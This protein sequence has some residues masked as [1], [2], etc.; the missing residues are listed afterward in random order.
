[1][2]LLAQNA[3]PALSARQ[4]PGLKVLFLTEM[5]ERF[6][7]YGMR[8]LLV[9]YLV[10]SLGY[11]SA[12]ALSLYGTYTMLVYITPLVGGWIADR[13]LGMRL[14]AFVGG[15]VM[16]LGHF[17]MAVPALLQIALGLLV[18]GNGLLK[19]NT[20][21]MV[22]ELYDGPAD[23]RRDGGY[24]IFYMG[25][26]LGA[27]FSG[28]VCGAVGETFGWHFGFAT[29]GA[30]MA[31]G[32]CTFVGG[33]RLLARAGLRAGQRALGRHDL[34]V[35]AAFVSGSV[36]LDLAV[37]AGWPWLGGLLAALSWAR[38]LACA[39]ALALPLLL[40]WRRA[41][42]R[43]HVPLTPAERRRVQAICVLAAFLVF[44]W[45]GVEQA[46]GSMSLFA[47]RQTD[48]RVAG[49]EFPASWFQSVDALFIVALAPF[50]S[51]LWTR[52]NNSR[53]PL[54]DVAKLG[55]S[56]MVMGLGFVVMHIA[57][58]HA[59][60]QGGSVGPQWLFGAYF[61]LAA[62]EV[63]LSPVGL[64]LLSRAAPA[65]SA[66]LLMGVWMLA[67]ALANKLAGSLEGL[68]AGSGIAPYFLLMNISIGLGLLLLALSPLL[69][70]MLRRA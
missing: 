4:P 70:R 18:I 55:L 65:R 33:Q 15:V 21:S 40:L 52:I 12:D 69:T 43:S 57:Q 47:D 59:G 14:A 34:P 60:R 31:V 6:S 10:H 27:I 1:M 9:L 63:M 25:I 45:T 58:H 3:D 56:M 13:F 22:G 61:F 36:A 53:W 35:V 42:A 23:P 32:L 16:M 39:A 48:R 19:P 49:F 5:W 11:T 68:L 50:L 7:F 64:S 28:L 46:G 20:T 44:F 67:V 2:T 24:T 29:A 54:S 41:L 51:M 26:N 66:A 38:L 37:V 8:A 62:G 17:A 30:G